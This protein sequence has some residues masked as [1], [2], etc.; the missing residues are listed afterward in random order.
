MASER[1]RPNR[2]MAP[3]CRNHMR[4]RCIIKPCKY[5]H[6]PKDLVPPDQ[7]EVEVCVDSLRNRCPRGPFD[8]RWYHPEQPLRTRL[9][10]EAGFPVLDEIPPPGPVFVPPGPLGLPPPILPA[11]VRPMLEVCHN[12]QKGR[13]SFSDRECK[14]AHA[15]P[16]SPDGNFVMVC[17]DFLKAGCTREACRFFHPLN[18]RKHFIREIPILTGPPPI[19]EPL[20]PPDPYAAYAKAVAMYGIYGAHI[21]DGGKPPPRR[22]EPSPYPLDLYAEREPRRREP[23]SM[24]PPSY[25]PAFPDARPRDRSPPGP[26]RGVYDS[27]PDRSRAGSYPERSRSET[28]PDRPRGGLVDA[29]AERSRDSYSSRGGEYAYPG[30]AG[31]AYRDEGRRGRSPEPDRRDERYR[32][33]ERERSYE[34]RD[35]R[36]RP[37]RAR[38]A[39]DKLPVCRDFYHDKC[40]RRACR[41]VHPNSRIRV[42][43]DDLTVDI[44]QDYKQGRCRD[45]DCPNYHPVTVMM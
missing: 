7:M 4:G 6:V 11:K 9:Q 38:L 12:W 16:T 37:V 42:N 31:E 29:Y 34:R 30:G 35:E 32:G 17:A 40:D 27:Y 5:A 22:E 28:Y 10:T 18:H 8:C 41:F 43:R 15:E 24:G 44:C 1:P 19:M 3:L 39:E 45:P 23:P 13:C 14:R 20:P 25:P 2:I 21:A 36:G 26:P 33:A